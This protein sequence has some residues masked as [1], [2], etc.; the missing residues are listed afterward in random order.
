MK[1]LVISDTHLTDRFDPKK[2]EFLKEII[3]DADQIIINGDFWDGFITDF[4]SFLNSPWKRLFP[5]LKRKKTIYV[6]GNHD[7]KQYCNSQTSLFSVLQ[8]N[9]YEL[10]L[11]NHRLIFEHGNRYRPALDEILGIKIPSPITRFAHWG[12]KIL[13]KKFKDRYFNLAYQRFNNGIKEIIKN[14]DQPDT[15]YFFGHTHKAEKDL[16]NRFFNTGIIK[17]GLG[18]YIL[19]D[20]EKIEIKER[21]YD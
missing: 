10:K 6:F 4:S 9:R 12:E 14:I 2:C 1:T 13:V 18:Q 11:N 8:T 16:P 5:L 7:K 21:W 20:N 19:I 3:T 15:Y 17:G